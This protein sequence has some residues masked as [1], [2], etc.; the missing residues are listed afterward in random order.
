MDFRSKHRDRLVAALHS[1]TLHDENLE[2]SSMWLLKNGTK[3]KPFS[4][5]FTMHFSTNF[6]ALNSKK[7]ELVLG[8]S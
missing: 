3:L 1:T 2:Q 7:K 8:N 4:F 6:P 5:S